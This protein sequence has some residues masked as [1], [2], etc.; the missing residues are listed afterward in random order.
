MLY[1]IDLPGSRLDI[2]GETFMPLTALTDLICRRFHVAAIALE[3]F[4][5]ASQSIFQ[6]AMSRRTSSEGRRKELTELALKH[7][8]TEGLQFHGRIAIHQQVERQLMEENYAKGMPPLSYLTEAAVGEAERFIFA[9]HTIRYAISA[10]STYETAGKPAGL[11][12]I[13]LNG[14]LPDL[15]KVR[16]SIAHVDERVQRLARGKPID[17]KAVHVPGAI[18]AV[19]GTTLITGGINNHDYYCTLDD[20]SVGIIPITVEKLAAVK[21]LIQT[22]FWGMPWTGPQTM[23]PAH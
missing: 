14:L 12:L 20:G 21:N 1:I 11:A 6:T 15:V 7:A 9:M 17:I 13:T 18:K 8:D 16:D 23:S 19:A 22:M 5:Y 2:E 3:S 4:H 10:L